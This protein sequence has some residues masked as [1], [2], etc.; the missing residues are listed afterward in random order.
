[1]H[2]EHH[3][4]SVQRIVNDWRRQGLS[5]GFVPTM[6]NLHAGH[7]ALVERARQLADKVVV[8][9]F[10]NPIQFGPSEDYDS[11]PRTLE[12]DAVALAEAGVHLL[13]APSVN[14]MYP[15]GSD[16][17]TRVTVPGVSDILD[18]ASRPGFF[19]GVATVVNK[20]FNIVPAN[21]AVFGEKDFQQLH[22]IHRMVADLNLPLEV[23]GA[24]IVREADGLAMSSRN[25]YLSA[26]ERRV[27]PTLYQVLCAARDRLR[28]GKTDFAAVEAEAVAE[29][30]SAGF[31]P[32][33]VAIHQAQSLQPAR[34]GDSRLVILAAAHLGGTRLIDN[35]TLE[36]Q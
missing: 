30:A 23:V 14:E 4:K 25:G 2:T 28:G 10:V 31:V 9:I 7:L 8:S 32:D 35:I 22:V 21:L 24:P 36:I 34:E 5:V 26:E 18:G 12:Q 27:A 6:G 19:T 13:F 20:L 1:M 3:I 17:Q 11:Y 33:Y 15:L 16:T 29:L